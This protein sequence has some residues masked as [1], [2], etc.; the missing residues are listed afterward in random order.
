MIYR[1][2]IPIWNKPAG[3]TFYKIANSYS[4]AAICNICG[5]RL[6]CDW[7]ECTDI[8]ELTG[9]DCCRSCSKEHLEELDD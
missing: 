2:K 8:R 3:L 6:G 7:Y 9:I 1:L 5:R 4:K